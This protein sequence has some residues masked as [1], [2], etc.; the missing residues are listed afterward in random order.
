MTIRH[1]PAGERSREQLIERGAHALR[2][3]RTASGPRYA[4]LKAA[5]CGSHLE[6]FQFKLQRQ[7]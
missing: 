5:V 1:W 4:I 7:P 2:V 3:R 6:P